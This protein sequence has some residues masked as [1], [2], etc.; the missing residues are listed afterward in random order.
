MQ[1]DNFQCRRMSSALPTWQTES[2]PESKRQ[3]LMSKAALGKATL[4]F[5]MM[6][7]PMDV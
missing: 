5:Q 6:D 2:P 4:S 3:N 1:S 7:V